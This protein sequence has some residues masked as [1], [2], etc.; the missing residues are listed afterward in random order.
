LGMLFQLD[1][2]L[3][4]NVQRPLFLLFIPILLCQKSGQ[5]F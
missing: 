2:D 3:I 4:T 5:K 1:S